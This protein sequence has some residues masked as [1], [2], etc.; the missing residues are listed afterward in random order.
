MDIQDGELVKSEL[1]PSPQATL[2]I[3]LVAPHSPPLT[4]L[5][6]TLGQSPWTPRFLAREEEE[7]P[8]CWG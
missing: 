7:E 6:P 4:A 1:P 5:S 8:V 2:Q 3:H